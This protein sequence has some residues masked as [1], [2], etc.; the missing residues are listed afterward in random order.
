MPQIWIGRL[1]ELDGY[2]ARSVQVI[3]QTCPR[4]PEVVRCQGPL[5][6]WADKNKKFD[7]APSQPE[8]NRR[9]DERGRYVL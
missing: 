1:N 5:A 7:A 9:V 8:G 2:G 6:D 4:V 3:N